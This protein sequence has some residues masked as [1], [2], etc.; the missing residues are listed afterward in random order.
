MTVKRSWMMQAHF[1]LSKN[2]LIFYSD[3]EI[4]KNASKAV[5]SGKR[6]HRWNPSLH[7][8]KQLTRFWQH[9]KRIKI[10]IL[11]KPSDYIRRNLLL[12]SWHK[13]H[14]MIVNLLKDFRFLFLQANKS[15]IGL[16]FLRLR[17][18]NF[19][20]KLEYCFEVSEMGLVL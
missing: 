12:S 8:W 11:N 3:R 13:F 20:K 16:K 6:A 14:K 1:F 18:S 4:C 2:A 5:I 7:R 9:F 19:I 15:T 17:A 10:L